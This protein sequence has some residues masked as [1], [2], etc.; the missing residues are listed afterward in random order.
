[1][2]RNSECFVREGS[3]LSEP[4]ERT[5][6]S[7]FASRLAERFAQ[8]GLEVIA[9]MADAQA[10]A[11]DCYEQRK[12]GVPE[13]EADTVYRELTSDMPEGGSV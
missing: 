6:K 5:W 12:L 10:H 13:Q 2:V 7:R 4:R 9:A 3:T 1:M 11:D 8:G